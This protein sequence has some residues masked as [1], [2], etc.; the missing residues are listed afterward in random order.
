[1]G[2][3]RGGLVVTNTKSMVEAMLRLY[4]DKVLRE[5][6]A[7]Q[8]AEWVRAKYDVSQVMPTLIKIIK[9]T[10]ASRTRSE[11]C[12]SL[13]EDSDLITQVNY[14]EVQSLLKNVMGKTSL[15]ER[16]LMRVVHNPYIY[17]FYIF[18]RTYL[19]S[20]RNKSSNNADL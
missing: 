1:V 13:K 18:M 2:H 11:L 4:S 14:K 15:R 7:R 9:I 6:F 5:K 20:H 17:K 8:G 3:E 10:L 12:A 16:V 19:N